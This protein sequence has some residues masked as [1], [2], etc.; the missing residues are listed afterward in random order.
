M[1]EKKTAEVRRLYKFKALDDELKMR[2]YLMS[3]L[4]LSGLSQENLNIIINKIGFTSDEAGDEWDN[5]LPTL[6]ENNDSYT[7]DN[8]IGV[9][10]IISIKDKKTDKDDEVER[11]I[12]EIDELI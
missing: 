5:T 6:E 10:K 7:E 1:E 8:E 11:K 9:G 3:Q 2:E 12:A 4:S